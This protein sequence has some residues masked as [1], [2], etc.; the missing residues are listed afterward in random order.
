M[1]EWLICGIALLLGG[2]LGWLLARVRSRSSAEELF[3]RARASE[4]QAAEFRAQV[5]M[6]RDESARFQAQIRQIENDRTAAVTRASEMEKAILEQRAILEEAKSKLSDTFKSLAADALK[7]SNQDFLTLA[8]QVLGSLQKEGVTDLES[9]QKS[10]EDIV[11]PLRETLDAYQRESKTLEEHRLVEHGAIAERLRE[12]AEANVKL[13]SETGK[14]VNALRTPQVRGRWGEITLRRCAELA[15]MSKH[16]DFVEQE[17]VGQD[18]GRLRPDMVVRLPSRREIVVDSKV[19]LNAYLEALEAT[20]PEQSKAALDRHVQQIRNHMRQLSSKEYW[21]QFKESPE[22]VVMFIPGEVFFSVAAERD[23]N[24][25]EEALGKRVMIATPTNFIGLLLSVAYGWRQEQL[26][27][28]AQHISQLGQEL[29]ERM[30]ILAEY[31]NEIGESLGRAVKSYN[32]AVA[33]IETRVLPAARKFKTLGAGSKK[34]MAEIPA[35]DQTP[36][37]LEIPTEEAP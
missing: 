32:A 25:F 4:A 24:L 8:K 23:P 18:G 31:L 26:A 19:A 2:V 11:K 28:N 30:A 9:R 10:I 22:F 37:R 35:L 12:V 33:S 17:T 3:G 1:T 34:E 6:L 15:G 27:E 20:S 14:L 16:C 13:Q 21:S 7:S 36:R 5:G 29:H